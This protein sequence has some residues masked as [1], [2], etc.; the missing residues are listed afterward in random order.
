MTYKKYYETL[1]LKS[2]TCRVTAR[3]YSQGTSYG[4]RHVCEAISFE[5]FKDK[6]TIDL[7]NIN[8]ICRYYNRTWE[9]WRFQTVLYKTAKRYL[10]DEQYKIIKEALR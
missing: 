8:I 5:I 1:D 4:F 9:C 3:V 6:T 7:P 10:D 2:D